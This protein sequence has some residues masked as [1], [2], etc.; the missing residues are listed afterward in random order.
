MHAT[1]RPT[2][3][4]SATLAAAAL[5]LLALVGA[6]GDDKSGARDLSSFDQ[7]PLTFR[8]SGRRDGGSSPEQRVSD[9]P[10]DAPG[11]A[12]PADGA[13]DQRSADLLSA[14]VRPPDILP[15]DVTPPDTVAHLCTTFGEFNCTPSTFIIKCNATCTDHNSRKLLIVCVGTNCTCQVNG[16]TK[17][18]C[19]SGA[20]QCN[21]CQQAFSCCG[22]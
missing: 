13:A 15:P 17:K 20:T 3:L 12:V 5:G 22:F 21:A 7:P 19:S 9:G 6:C 1:S 4:A 10:Q 14:D 16:T 11:D 18:T 8:D 2:S